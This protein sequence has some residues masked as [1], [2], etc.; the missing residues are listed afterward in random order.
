[1]GLHHD[2]TLPSSLVDH[3]ATIPDPR[4]QRGKSYEWLY[5]LTLIVAA[6]MTGETSPL[7]ISDW[8]SAHRQELVESLQ[9]VRRRVPCLST[10][11]RALCSIA[12]GVGAGDRR[13]SAGPCQRDG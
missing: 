8:V 11:R 2:T 1:M 9:P 3:L 7:G 5:L 10:L 12:R 6:M 13:L 4:R